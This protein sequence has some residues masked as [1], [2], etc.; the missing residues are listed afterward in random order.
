MSERDGVRYRRDG[1]KLCI[2]L[3]VKQVR[4]LFDLRD[5]APFKERDLDPGVVEYLRES[6]T[7]IPRAAE[8]KLDVWISDEAEPSLEEQ[9]IRDAILGYFRGALQQ[10]RG[11]LIAHMRQGQVTL[12]VGVVV[13]T[14]MLTAAKGIEVTPGAPAWRELAKEGLTIG[15]WVAIWRPVEHFLYDWWP[16]LQERRLLLRLAAL[17]VEVHWGKRA[18]GD[19]GAASRRRG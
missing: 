16:F 1:S 11:Q 13:L 4:Q 14:V 9:A 7:E 19:G 18:P 8:V 3:V 6:L 2:D 10:L 12:F 5:P 15:A 17:G